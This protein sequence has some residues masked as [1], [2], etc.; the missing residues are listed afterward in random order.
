[1]RTR[2]SSIV[3]VS[4]AISSQHPQARIR[5]RQR[6]KSR[7]Q[8]AYVDRELAATILVLWRAG[9]PTEVSCQ[10]DPGYSGWLRTGRITEAELHEMMNLIKRSLRVPGICAKAYTN[11]PTKYLIWRPY[12]EVGEW[13]NGGMGEWGNGEGNGGMGEWGNGEGEGRG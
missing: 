3:V 10:G 13:G 7:W 5:Y 9:Y 12:M 1:M 6:V 4:R 11:W 2:H 8:T